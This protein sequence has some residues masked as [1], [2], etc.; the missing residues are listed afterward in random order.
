MR[1]HLS[2]ATGSSCF[3]L[4]EQ[5]QRVTPQEQCQALGN[6]L[7]FLRAVV[8]TQMGALPCAHLPF[9]IAVILFHRITGTQSPAHA[10]RSSCPTATSAP[11]AGK[12]QLAPEAE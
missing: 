9:H 3:C 7:C 2:L 11:W 4:K 8:C 5:Q 12:Y 6:S 10:V 1:C